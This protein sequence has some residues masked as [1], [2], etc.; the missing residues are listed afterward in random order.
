[1]TAD[2][3]VENA[4]EYLA[5]VRPHKVST[6]PPSVLVREC[7]ELRRHLGQVLDAIDQAGDD[8]D[9]TEPYCTQCRQWIGMFLGMDGWHHFRGDP[10]PGSVRELYEADHEPVIA[11]TVPPGRGLSPAQVATIRDGLADA[12]DLLEHRAGQWCD[13]CEQSP[14]EV[15]D[16]HGADIDAASRY[17]QVARE[18]GDAQ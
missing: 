8:D 7:T 2:Q 18:I 14:A 11:W 1:M 15:C 4:R 10:A 3:R 6:R 16:E 13:A 17:R 9:G 12:A 5:S